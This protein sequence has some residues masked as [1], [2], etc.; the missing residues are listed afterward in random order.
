MK[1][2]LEDLELA[3]NYLEY[4]TDGESDAYG[5]FDAIRRVITFLDSEI[6]KRKNITK[7]AERKRVYAL[8]HGIPIR[9]VRVTK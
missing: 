9:Q 7:L 3:A 5:D 4:Q 6:T 2:T 8:E 1:A